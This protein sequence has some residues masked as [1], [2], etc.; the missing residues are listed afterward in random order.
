MSETNTVYLVKLQDGFAKKGSYSSFT[1]VKHP[2]NASIYAKKLHA[3]NLMDDVLAHI[4]LLNK[5]SKNSASKKLAKIPTSSVK[6][7]GLE[8]SYKEVE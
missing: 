6:V 3:D 7:V 5:Y 8:F 4:Q 1:V 2:E